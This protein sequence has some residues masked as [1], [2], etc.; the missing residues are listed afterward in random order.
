[1]VYLGAKHRWQ[2]NNK[3]DFEDLLCDDV[4]EIFLAYDTD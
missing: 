1:M 2:D 4:G 3:V